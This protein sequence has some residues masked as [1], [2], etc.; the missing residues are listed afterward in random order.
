MSNEGNKVWQSDRCTGGTSLEGL[1]EENKNFLAF[2][3]FL[4]LFFG[5]CFH[6]N[7]KQSFKNE[8]SCVFKK[9]FYFLK[10]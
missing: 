1:S 9:Y 6:K 10:F 8:K 4:F 3:L 2:L 5:K 7:K